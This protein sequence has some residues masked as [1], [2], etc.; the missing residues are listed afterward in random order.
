MRILV[1]FLAVFG[2]A[3]C[4]VDGQ[5]VTPKYSSKTTVGYNSKTGPFSST[6]VGIDLTGG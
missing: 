4:G 5:P 2:L 3:A 1:G 6:S